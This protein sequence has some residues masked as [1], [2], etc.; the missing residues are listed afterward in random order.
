MINI[1]FIKHI[2]HSLL[3]LFLLINNISAQFNNVTVEI[4]EKNIVFREGESVSNILKVI[5]GI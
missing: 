2:A 4:R 3:F 1:R 5:N